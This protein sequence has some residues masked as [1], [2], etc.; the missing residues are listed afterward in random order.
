MLGHGDSSGSGTSLGSRMPR[1]TSDCNPA[2][3][4]K[5]GLK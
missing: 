2:N 1:Q 4:V 5:K 3:L